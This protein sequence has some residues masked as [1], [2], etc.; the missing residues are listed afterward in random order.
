MLPLWVMDVVHAAPSRNPTHRPARRHHVPPQPP[1]RTPKKKARGDQHRA[2]KPRINKNPAEVRHKP[3][4]EP[5]TPRG[6]ASP[7]NR[8]PLTTG[9]PHGPVPAS[10]L[11]DTNKPWEHVMARRQYRWRSPRATPTRLSQRILARL[12]L[13]AAA[14]AAWCNATGLVGVLGQTSQDSSGTFRL[15][16]RP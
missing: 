15:R 14:L 8:Q 11:E 16:Q 2:C 5:G 13:L 10:P 7:S 1:R 6:H 3:S 9:P 4:I 12:D